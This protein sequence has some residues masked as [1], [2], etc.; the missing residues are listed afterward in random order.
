MRKSFSMMLALVLVFT[1]GTV[2]FAAPSKTAENLNN[3]KTE[4]MVVK[5]ILEPT[6]QVA[7]ESALIQGFIDSGKPVIQYF[8][9]EV[10]DAVA[11]AFPGVDLSKLVMHEFVSV[12]EFG[13]D[14]ETM[15]DVE[16]KLTFATPYP[17]GAKLAVLAG[18]YTDK[19]ADGNW[20]ATWYVCP[21]V[22]KDGLVVVTLPKEFLGANINGN[23][24][25]AV[26]SLE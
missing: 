1:M 16:A 9:K 26:L 8:P 21:A 20:K 4:G 7:A 13:Y 6:E 19:D 22:V 18:L 14:P 15:G 2:A 12:E 11:L 24:V 5:A 3:S 17:E 25:F 23:A 10:Q